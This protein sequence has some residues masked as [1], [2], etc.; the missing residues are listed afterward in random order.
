MFKYKVTQPITLDKIIF[1]FYKDVSNLK[2]VLE[3]NPTLK[4]KLI[5]ESGDIVNLPIIKQ[6]DKKIELKRLWD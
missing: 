4:N 3:A 5:L 1:N 2:E 6:T